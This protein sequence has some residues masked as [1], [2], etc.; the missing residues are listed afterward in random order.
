MFCL[1]S[2]VVERLTKDVS[3]QSNLTYR[4]R[5]RRL[6]ERDFPATK[7]ILSKDDATACYSD[8]LYKLMCS[9]L[10]QRWLRSLAVPNLHVFA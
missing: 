8:R 10:T 9:I 2:V 6:D 3:S 5:E 4:L 7:R 1:P